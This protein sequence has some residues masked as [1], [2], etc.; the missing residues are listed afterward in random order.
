LHEIVQPSDPRPN[1]RRMVYA[2]LIC[3]D[4]ACADELEAT[5]TLEE[6]DALA[7]ECGCALQVIAVS[8]VEFEEPVWEWTYE[9]AAA[10]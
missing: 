4:E 5:G 10:A 9:L 8:V 7:C 2:L 3:S 1:I 6:L